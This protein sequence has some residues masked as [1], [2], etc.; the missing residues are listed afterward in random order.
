MSFIKLP[1]G[2]INRLNRRLSDNFGSIDNQ[3]N[4]RLIWS[5]DEFENRYTNY[6]REGFQ[7]QQPEV[8]HLPKYR[9]WIHDKHILERLTAVPAV[10]GNDL[11]VIRSYEPL[12]VFENSKGPTVPTWHVLAFIVT[13]VLNAI[14]TQGQYVKYKDPLSDPKTAMEVQ[15]ARIDSLVEE[16]FP[17]ET[18][19][20]DALAYKDGVSYAGIEMPRNEGEKR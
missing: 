4:F 20:G 19:L 15:K 13:N 18:D 9:Q 1:K 17:N 3:A 5:E 11:T 8:Q 14:R 2:E 10:D 12:H 6:T 16:L 7:L